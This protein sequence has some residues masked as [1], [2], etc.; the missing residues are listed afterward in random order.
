MADKSISVNKIKI[1]DFIKVG[2]RAI[3]HMT[4]MKFTGQGDSWIVEVCSPAGADGTAPETDKPVKDIRPVFEKLVGEGFQI[5]C[6]TKD[7][8]EGILVLDIDN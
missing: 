7:G 2:G 3:W 1:S 4:C 6:V 8:T 5:N